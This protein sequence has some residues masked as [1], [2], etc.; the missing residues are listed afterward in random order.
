MRAYWFLSGSLPASA[1][2]LFAYV[3]RFTHLRDLF[4]VTYLVCVMLLLLLLLLL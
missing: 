2:A 1:A 4:Y 3:V